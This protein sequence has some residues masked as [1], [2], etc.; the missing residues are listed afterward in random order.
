MINLN[1]KWAL[2][3]GASRG[4]GKYISLSLAKQGCN[5]IL[6]SRN[7][8]SLT[9]LQEQIQKEGVRTFLTEQDFSVPSAADLLLEKIQ[10]Q[11]ITVD[12]LVNNAGVN[13][14]IDKE[15]HDI[16]TNFGNWTQDE[17]ETTVRINTVVPAVLAS[18][19][20]AQ[21]VRTGF[22]RIVNLTSDIHGAP[23]HLIYSVSKGAV[24]KL[25]CDLA[26]I[27]KETNVAVSAVEPG[28]CRTY[29]GG[30]GASCT[31]QNTIPGV[32]V[33]ICMDTGANGR[34]FHAQEFAGMSLKAAVSYAADRI[35]REPQH[36]EKQLPAV[37]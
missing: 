2:V 36:F 24:D 25:T 22:G 37:N 19:L 18:R 15:Q 9:E 27:V 17:Y 14:S 30:T 13:L 33:P 1:G 10:N 29:L 11:N 21:M 4:I 32:L 7:L 35:V 23:D 6:H 28:W 26:E 16:C 8:A 5:L 34:F 20:A 3:T 12:I 31:P